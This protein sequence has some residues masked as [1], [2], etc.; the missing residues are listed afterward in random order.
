M[1]WGGGC[2]VL[3][4]FFMTVNRVTAPYTRRETRKC[5]TPLTEDDCSAAANSIGHCDTAVMRIHDPDQPYGCILDM[6]VQ[7]SSFWTTCTGGLF[8]N[9]DR[10]SRTVCTAHS[11]CL[12]WEGFAG[13]N[14]K[15]SG[16]CT[17]RVQ[18]VSECELAM[19]DLSKSVTTCAKVDWRKAP[20]GCHYDTNR[21]RCFLNTR[22]TTKECSS[23]RECV[24]GVYRIVGDYMSINAGS[25]TTSVPDQA[26]CKVAATELAKGSVEVYTR[27]I[28]AGYAPCTWCTADCGSSICSKLNGGSDCLIWNTNPDAAPSTCTSSYQC[29]CRAPVHTCGFYMLDS[30]YCPI[31]L[32]N[33][34]ECNM[35]RTVLN[36]VSVEAQEVQDDNHPEGCIIIKERRSTSLVYNTD[37]KYNHPCKWDDICICKDAPTTQP[38]CTC[39]QNSYDP[40]NDGTYAIL[41][42]S[43]S[44]PIQRCPGVNLVQLHS[45]ADCSAACDQLLSIVT[46]EMHSSQFPPGCSYMPLENKC[47]YNTMANPSCETDTPPT[48]NSNSDPN[49]ARHPVCEMAR[50]TTGVALCPT[51]ASSQ[52]PI[53]RPSVPPSPR[54]SAAPSGSPSSTPSSAAPT[55]APVPGMTLHPTAPPTS[56]PPTASPTR[57]PAVSPSTAPSVYPSVAPSLPPTLGPVHAPTVRPT[58]QP[59]TSGPS[60]SP[61]VSPSSDPAQIPTVPPSGVTIIRPSSHPTA[62]PTMHPSAAPPSAR[63]SAAPSAF[64]SVGPS[65][66]STALPTGRPSTPLSTQPSKFP[67]RAPLTPSLSPSVPPWLPASDSPSALPTRPSVA[68]TL[69]PVRPPHVSPSQGPT[70]PTL[71]PSLSPNVAPQSLPTESPSALPTRPPVTP[72]LAPTPRPSHGPT[73]PT[74]TPSLSPSVA[75]G[76]PTALP[77]RIPLL[78]TFAPVPPSQAPHGS[79]SEP[80]AGA[81]SVAPRS[82]PS[83]APSL[84]PTP[85]PHLQ[86]Y[87]A[88]VTPEVDTTVTGMSALGGA[89]PSMGNLAMVDVEC[90]THVGTMTEL[91]RSL[92][93]TG[94]KIAGSSYFGCL[95]G[96]ALVALGAGIVSYMALAAIRLIDKN[97]DGILNSDEIK[98]SC[99][100]RIPGMDELEAVDLAGVV[101]HPNTVLVVALFLYQGSSFAALRLVIE[102]QDDAGNDVHITQRI[103]GACIAFLLAGFPFWQRN[104]VVRGLRRIPRDELPGCG[105]VVRARMRSWDDPKPPR[106]LQ[107]VLLSEHGDWV[108][109]HRH[110]HWVSSWEA[111]VRNYEADDAP[112]AML[113]ELV[114][115]FVL[116]LI[117]AFP[118]SSY[119]ACGAVRAAS[120]GVHL[121]QLA[122][123]LGR[124]PYRAF[125]DDILRSLTLALLAGALLQLAIVFFLAARE[126]ASDADESANATADASSGASAPDTSTAALILQITTF[127]VL[128]QALVRGIAEAIL[129]FKGWRANSQTLEWSENE[130][131]LP[132]Y[133]RL[134]GSATKV[135]AAPTEESGLPSPLQ[136]SLFEPPLAL[137]TLGTPQFTSSVLLSPQSRAG[138]GGA[139][140]CKE[141]QPKALDASSSVGRGAPR[142]R[143]GAAQGLPARRR[144]AAGRG[145]G[146]S[147][148]PGTA[149][150]RGL[151]GSF[152]LGRPGRGTGPQQR[153]PARMRG[154]TVRSPS[155]GPPGVRTS[156]LDLTTPEITARSMQNIGPYVPGGDSRPLPASNSG[157]GSPRLMNRRPAC[158]AH[159]P[160]TPGR[161]MSPTTPNWDRASAPDFGAAPPA[162]EQQRSMV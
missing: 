82:R 94:I 96:N 135:Q 10:T 98:D 55:E 27:D 107:W 20:T 42:E 149:V 7:T 57:S 9:S 120:A 38:I 122:Y 81:P 39:R 17:A 147:F 4:A 129:F 157:R 89:G 47:Y 139:E 151:G 143:P 121:V 30:G 92:H 1:Q 137:S 127:V 153:A 3:A 141:V 63:P 71:T 12:C 125:R 140:S 69:V 159:S 34:A 16:T 152:G 101:R 65:P 124:R 79:P 78:P 109:T 111:A 62:L 11:V 130:G 46:D 145:L 154:A 86:P 148:T 70:H 87:R 22:V 162:G 67:S 33:V 150:G 116:S 117:N 37:R 52:S 32:D 144:V 84:A 26:D 75:T 80:P 112:T 21:N 85:L 126:D 158:G 131:S 19:K 113:V 138:S 161:P 35:A 8:W 2:W 15:T 146:D 40:C 103:A 49:T 56:G 77:T 72:T 90:Q 160:R 99:L 59:G 134:G 44:S 123:C 24:C 29:L 53:Q 114:A 18:S 23:E 100:G 25:C 91:G 31:P 83:A 93:P 115:M 13:F 28:G 128:L 133:F 60:L 118:T 73:H 136:A 104:S 132:E 6:N 50:C 142:W 45:R 88:K 68:P 119:T 64:H 105:P 36:V 61:S 5:S 54:P 41:P 102:H 48:C 108:S 51:A 58:P 156:I 66:R 97:G 110:K 14:L 74:L 95:A 43:H 106:W 76:R 155:G